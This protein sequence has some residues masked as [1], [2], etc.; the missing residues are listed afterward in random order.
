M[1][2]ASSG[3]GECLKVQCQAGVG[4]VEF[5]RPQQLYFCLI[6]LAGTRQYHTAVVAYPEL[7]KSDLQRFVVGRQ[8]ILKIPASLIAE[9]EAVAPCLF[10]G[11]RGQLNSGRSLQSRICMPVEARVSAPRR[12]LVFVPAKSC[13]N[14]AVASGLALQQDAGILE[15]YLRFAYPTRPNTS[16][17]FFLYSGL[18][19]PVTIPLVNLADLN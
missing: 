4:W 9:R 8:G 16:S 12:R 15:V 18:R 7:V 5:G 11:L 1:P 13:R 17:C 6:H 10:C 2:A 3:V 19:V 14:A